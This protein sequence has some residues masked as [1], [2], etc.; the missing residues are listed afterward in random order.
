MSGH[1]EKQKSCEVTYTKTFDQAQLA[2]ISRNTF[3]ADLTTTTVEEKCR[4]GWPETTCVTSPI[5][6]VSIEP[7]WLLDA[8]NYQIEGFYQTNKNSTQR[9]E[10]FPALV[11]LPQW[12]MATDMNM[13]GISTCISKILR[14]YL[15]TE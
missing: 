12:E 10:N 2:R 1:Q 7:G 8:G 5:S 11:I 13:S 9:V 4:S 3:L 6:I 14:Y 15:S